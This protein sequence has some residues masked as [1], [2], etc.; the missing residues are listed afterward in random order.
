MWEVRRF[1]KLID[2]E[3]FH[4]VEPAAPHHQRSERTRLIGSDHDQLQFATA[5]ERR[6][7]GLDPCILVHGAVGRFRQ[8]SPALRLAF[9]RTELA[10]DPYR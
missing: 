10:E 4:P 2:A 9:N 7:A 8:E 5:C 6:R 1:V 3:A